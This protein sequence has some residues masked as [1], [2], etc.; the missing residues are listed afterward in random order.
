MV[1]KIRT[2]G[3]IQK[4]K[5][6]KILFST[7]NLILKMKKKLCKKKWYPLSFRR[8]GLTR[9]PQSTP[10]QNTVGRYTERYTRTDVQKS[11][12]LI[13]D[14]FLLLFLPCFNQICPYLYISPL[15]WMVLMLSQ[16]LKFFPFWSFFLSLEFDLFFTFYPFLIKKMSFNLIFHLCLGEHFYYLLVNIERRP[17]SPLHIFLF[18]HQWLVFIFYRNCNTRDILCIMFYWGVTVLLLR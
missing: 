7:K 10:Y 17:C 18:N 2:Y 11:S 14:V 5:R 4:E 12:C 8:S 6:K 3:K 1:Q 16:F 9:S 15:L 13:F